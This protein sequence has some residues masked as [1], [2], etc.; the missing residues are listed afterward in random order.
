MIRRGG[1]VIKLA[2]MA[3]AMVIAVSAP[4]ASTSYSQPM[5]QSGTEMNY[6][7]FA[8]RIVDA[9]KLQ[10]GDRV[11]IRF[12]P[13]YFNQLVAPLRTR[14]RAADAI[15]I[16]AL[17]YVETAALRESGASGANSD[18][19]LRARFEAQSRAFEQLLDSVDVYLWL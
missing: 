6:E 1:N 12:D 7:A 14:I 8:A 16:G 10:A 5:V 19:R 3:L 2:L 13:G 11:L 15:D 17:E 4:Q 18:A 9:L